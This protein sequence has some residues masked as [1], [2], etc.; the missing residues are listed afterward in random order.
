MN[1]KIFLLV[2]SIFLNA[3]SLASATEEPEHSQKY[4][5][6]Q[7]AHDHPWL[8]NTIYLN[9]L[10][11]VSLSAGG[12][13]RKLFLPYA[14]TGS[15]RDIKNL[16]EVLCLVGAIS[17]TVFTY[18][19]IHHNTILGNIFDTTAKDMNDKAMAT[20]SAFPTVSGFLL[21]TL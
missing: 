9:S 6:E 10:L 18:N 17:S 11:A 4:K 12:L 8:F 19:S 14:Q 3:P 7:W 16:K 2:L 15:S 21:L 5:L 13:F 20:L 1:R